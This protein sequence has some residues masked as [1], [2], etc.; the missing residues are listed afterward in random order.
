MTPVLTVSPD[1]P[2]RP[3]PQPLVVALG[4]AVA[5]ALA[6]AVG[7][8]GS[9]RGL[10]LFAIGL[11]LGGTLLAAD[12]GFAGAFRR[13]AI[14]RDPSGLR[15]HLFTFSV[16]ML[17]IVPLV[18]L[19]H[20]LGVDVDGSAHRIGIALLT[21]GALFGAGMQLA[22]GC[23]SGT[24]Y[25]LGGGTAKHVGT[26]AGFLAGS[27]LAATHLE[28][29]WQLPSFPALTLFTLGPW[30]LT[31][32]LAVLAMALAFRAIPGTLPRRIVIGG[33]LLALLNAATVLASGHTWSETWAF[34]LWGT[35]LA[36]RAGAHPD[37][38]R[39]FRDTAWSTS[40]WVERTSIMDMAI[41]TGAL[42]AAGVLG[43]FRFTAASPRAWVAATIGGLA[44]GYGAR[45]AGGCNIGAYFSAI[46]TGD[47]SGWAWALAA[48]GGSVL[49]VRARARLEG[50]P[51]SPPP[52]ATVL[53]TETARPE[54]SA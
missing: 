10:V 42:L 30:P 50:V 39:V 28:R 5:G 47:L 16:A 21:G 7:Q 48:L 15:A 17:A 32:G 25:Q 19:E 27:V 52:P 44:M 37:T 8:A 9:A 26:L 23:A 36:A 13:L 18:A 43:R 24:L 3:S 34:T 12:F 35:Q 54:R 31:L 41:P 20:V 38:W 1:S 29:W 22:G 49:G 45:L 14:E 4:V 40:P 51:A 2:P 11:G 6:L 53:A 33:A 46:A